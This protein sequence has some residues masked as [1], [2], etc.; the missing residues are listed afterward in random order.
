MHK[1]ALRALSLFAALAFVHQVPA[2][3]PTPAEAL[4]ARAVKVVA[5]DARAPYATYTVVVTM[6]NENRKVVSSW[7]TTEDITRGVVLAS[8]FSEQERAQPTTSHGFNIKLTRRMPTPA[9]KTVVPDLDTTTRWVSTPPVSSEKSGDVVG[10]VALAVDQNFGLTPPR[11]YR[12]ASDRRTVADAGDELPIIGRTGR[13]VPRYRIELLD[14]DAGI[15]H[16]ALTPLRD[17]YHNRLREVWV[18][19]DT[20]IVQRAIVS[21]VGD[22]PPFDHV[23]W[24]ATFER[25]EGATYVNEVHPVEALKLGRDT[26]DVSI[27]FTSVVLRSQSPVTTTFGIEAPVRYLRDP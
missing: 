2:P 25:R 23:R 15:T 8:S 9:V 10:P 18:E 21:G 14:T 24:Q 16:L 17:A 20:A 26:P 13:T 11:A 5:D 1:A 27:A 19:T 22:R 3:E 4:F 12:V 6:T 7:A